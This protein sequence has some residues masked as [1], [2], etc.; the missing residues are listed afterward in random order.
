MPKVCM[1]LCYPKLELR[2]ITIPIAWLVGA[3]GFDIMT[4]IHWEI[5]SESTKYA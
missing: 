3:I 4:E 5:Q 1:Q 2:T